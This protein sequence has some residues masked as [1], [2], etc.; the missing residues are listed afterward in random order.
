MTTKEGEAFELSH[1]T[2]LVQ[3]VELRHQS[4]AA[5]KKSEVSKSQ[6]PPQNFAQKV[7]SPKNAQQRGEQQKYAASKS[8]K[9]SPAT[10]TAEKSSGHKWENELDFVKMTSQK[11]NNFLDILKAKSRLPCVYRAVSISCDPKVSKRILDITVKAA[12]KAF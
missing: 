2:K 5:S 1:S 6:Q 9:S 4:K 7:D 10:L 12:A 3:V 11:A 8:G